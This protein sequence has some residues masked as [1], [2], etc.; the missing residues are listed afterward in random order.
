MAHFRALS[1]GSRRAFVA[2]V[3]GFSWY[4]RSMNSN[5][6]YLTTSIA[7]TNAGP[8]IGHAQESVAADVVA[9][10]YRQK[11]DD[12]F[13]LTGTDENGTKIYQKAL[14]EGKPTQEFV[15]EISA[16]FKNLKKLLNLSWDN[17]IRTSDQ[18]THWPKVAEIWQKIEQAGDLYKKE[19]EGLY[20][21]GC[22]AFVRE[23]D[24]KNGKC[25]AHQKTPE[26]IKE[27]NYFF[28]LS[29]Y[30][31]KIKKSIES[32]ELSI[33]PDS[34]RN[35]ALAFLERGLE[36][37]SFSRPASKLPWGI[38][39]P[40]DPPAGGQVIY[41][42]ADALTNY[43]SGAPTKF[44]P[45]DLHIV[46]KDIS[47]FHTI[48]WPAMLLSA[49]IELPKKI[50]VHGFI[51]VDGEKMSKSLG[52]VI[53]PDQLVEKFGVDATR[54][55]LLKL[56]SFS[57]DSDFSFEKA[58]ATYN[59]DLANELGNL[60]LRVLTLAKKNTSPPC[61]FERSEK[62]LS[63][64]K[65]SLRSSRD[66][67]S[68]AIKNLNFQGALELIWEPVKTANKKIDELKLWELVKS[69][70]EKAKAE[71]EKILS[72]L[73]AV[74]ENLAPFLPETSIKIKKQVEELKVGKPL[75]PRI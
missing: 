25:P 9:R 30:T 73:L 10:F 38:P 48:I 26:K 21:A 41:V 74:A 55:I 62:S 58:I 45:A 42:W 33:A 64:V 3:L 49:G 68:K 29:K 37:I 12:V 66:D 56:L 52:N 44:W 4:T 50:F 34:R 53:P 31:D 5:K 72:D 36:D 23:G 28:R 13:F 63:K 47:R 51:S 16:Q 59:S 67:I 1:A 2:C 75:F 60:V 70:P 71:L 8:H 69:E 46:G 35:E 18:K 22:E 11:N 6:F 40:G 14:A 27:E 19:Y 15:D 17:F 43:I 39:V 54:Y 7:Y 61:H 32:N 24:L 65:G 57:E 20:C